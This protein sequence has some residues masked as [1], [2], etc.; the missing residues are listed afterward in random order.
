VVGESV[1]FDAEKILTE[2]KIGSDPEENDF[3]VSASANRIAGWIKMWPVMLS[4]SGIRS[5]STA[6][7]GQIFGRASG[8]IDPHCGP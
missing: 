5:E 4:W 2:P 1:E 6:T 7:P 3:G 8:L